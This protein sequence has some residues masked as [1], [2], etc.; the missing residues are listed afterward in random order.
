MTIFKKRLIIGLIIM[1]ILSPAGIVLPELFNS[2]DAWGEWGADDVNEMLGFTPE[3]MERL[4]SVWT[5]LIPDYN[6]FSEETPLYLNLISYI[7]SAVIGS[8]LVFLFI[9]LILKFS[10]NNEHKTS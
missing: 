7:I 5:S 4:S 9:R 8:L 1:I 10:Y 6:L 3:G 2:G